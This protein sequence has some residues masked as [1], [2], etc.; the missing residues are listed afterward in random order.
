MKNNLCVGIFTFSLKGIFLGV[1]FFFLLNMNSVNAQVTFTQ[2][3]DAD[4]NKGVLNNVVVSS[5]NVTL[6]NAASNPGLW[7]TGTT[8]LPQNL[9]GHKTATANN[10]Y[11]YL[12]GGYNGSAYSNGVYVATIQSAGISAWTT[13]NALPVAV[14]DPAVVVAANI[15]YVLGGRNATQVFNNIYYA[16]INAD[17]TIGAW[18]TSA[19]ALPVSLWG[20]SA[21]YLNGFIYVAGGTNLPSG[22][23]A[24]NTMYY[25]KLKADNSLS[26]FATGT[27]LPGAR[28][29]HSMV[30]YNNK[31]YLLGGYDNSGTKTNTVYF[32]TP[33]MNGPAGSWLSGTDLPVALSNHSTVVSNGLIMV[34]G[35][36]TSTGL[37]NIIYYAN[38]DQALPLTWVTSVNNMFDF[39]KDGSAFPGN[40]QVIYTG[41][42]SQAGNILSNCRYATFT[43][44]SNY[45][46]HG[47]FVSCPFYELGTERLINSLA[48]TST[49]NATY[50]NCQVSYRLAGSDKIWG[51]WASLTGTSPITVN[52]TKQFVQYSVFL[53]GQ[54]TYNV[55]F[56]DMSFT[57][58]G[59][60]LNG[61]LNSITAFTAAASPY[62]V[63]SSISF[64]SGT[65]T[66]QPGTTVLF[67]PGTGMSVSQASI[68][69]NGTA[70]DS[71][72]FMNLGVDA[73]LWNGIYFDANSNT[74]VSSQF[75]YTVI[76]GAG[77]GTN[78]AN[79][80]CNSTQQ[81]YLSQCNIRNADGN[82][83]TLVSSNPSFQNTVIKG[84]TENG[85]HLTNSNPTATICNISYNASAGIYSNATAS[86]LNGTTIH[87]NFYGIRYTSPNL[88]IAQPVGSPTLND[89]TYNGISIDG[90]DITTS[91]KTWN[92]L[93]YSYFIL[94][95]V[96]IMKSAANVRLTIK[97]G[98]TIKVANGAQI[99]VGN[100][101]SWD[102]Y[103][104][105]LFAIGTADSL[106]TFT[107]IN[108]LA[109]GWNGIYFTDYSDYNGG[110]SQLVYCVIE[111][112]NEYNI[113]SENTIQPDVLNYCKIQN[114][115]VDGARYT[116]STATGTIDH[117]QFLNNGRYPLW[118]Q[119]IETNPVHV[120]NTY[121][122]NAINCIVLSGGYYTFD[123]T[124]YYGGA[125]YYVLSNIFV[126][127]YQARSRFTIMP[128]VTLAF[129]QGTYLQIGTNA[130]YGG[131][132]I[133]EGKP[134]SLIT[135]KPY[136]NSIGGWGG[137]NFDDP[138]NYGS[139]SS[140]KY[141]KIEKGATYNVLCYY[142]T[143]PTMEHCILDQSAG[144]GINLE[145][146]PIVMT[147]CT[148]SNSGAIG[149]NASTFAGSIANCTITNSDS[150]GINASSFTGSILNSTISNSGSHG[151]VA[152]SSTGTVHNNQFLNNHGYPIKYTDVSCDFHLLGN[153][154]I[155]NTP[156]YIALS[157]G[158]YWSQNF[159][160]Y[161]DGIPYHVLNNIRILYTSIYTIKPGVTLAF[162]TGKNLQI[163]TS[164]WNTFIGLNAEGNVDSVITFKPYNNAVGGWGGVYF[165]SHSNYGTS[166]LKYCKIE[167]AAANNILCENTTQPLIEHCE[168]TQSAGSG[169]KLTNSTLVIRNSSF[170]KNTLNGIML[171][172]SSNTAI[173]DSAAN[174]CNLYYNG[175]YNIYNN[176]T[177]NIKA[178]YNFW[179][180]RDSVE[181]K[182]HIY[183]KTDNAA[184]GYVFIR[185]FIDLPYTLT[186]SMALSGTAKYANT[187]SSI[188]NNAK[189]KLSNLGNPV[190]ST[191]TNA[192]GE[193]NFGPVKSG[194]YNL[195]IKPA[196]SWGGVNSTDALL[197]LNHTVHIS[198]LSGI[199]LAAADVNKSLYVN[200]T[201]ALLVMNRFVG[202]ISS[203]PSGDTFMDIDTIIVNGGE[204]DNDLKMLWFGD[205]NASFVPSAKKIESSVSL[206]QEGSIVVPSFTEFNLP[207]KIKEGHEIGAISFGFYYPE[208]FFE[209][210]GVELK[211]S[212]AKFT[213][214]A[215]D[216]LFRLAWCDPNAMTVNDQEPMV[217]LTMKS[218]N[219]AGLDQN[220]FFT[221]YENSELA[222]KSGAMIDGAVL[223]IPAIKSLPYGID[224]PSEEFT[225]KTYPNPFN[226]HCFI[227]FTLI[228]ESKVKII[229]YDYLGGQVKQV[230]E[231][232]YK[233]GANQVKFL[234]PDLAPGFY[235][236]KIE[237]TSNGQSCS[238]IMKVAVSK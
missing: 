181:I 4:F 53:T 6:Q 72:K 216:G 196:Q 231:A 60:A 64:T 103:G 84:N 171:E 230:D 25:T 225:V 45:V 229:L 79:L 31:L 66:F 1:L 207:V 80:Y 5:N 49:F 211:N 92:T 144:N 234:A 161:N 158:D 204:V 164:S 188:L 209:V 146:S 43:L 77:Y 145:S 214:S 189:L 233:K 106:I 122:G 51:D 100:N 69:C 141:C 23:S 156:N 228:K 75:F 197:I 178:R 133:A 94:G 125:P 148:I 174:S 12:V 86:I 56:S 224:G 93:P 76:A 29:M 179:G 120:N 147:N 105:E 162:A 220:G 34:L 132:L 42:I 131:E 222:D 112:G 113:F 83:I 227:D 107:S 58:P 218:L 151:L 235:L 185:P 117:S 97:P 155:G 138:D 61:N 65:H 124:L 57:T 198:L 237:I 48:F 3:T 18:Q 186:D 215:K 50:T 44:T 102:P 143:Q 206:V 126:Y 154:Y 109:G 194:N 169:L 88:A 187:V 201:D 202:N 40:G 47:V 99:W 128:G 62:I 226:D 32:A 11:V 217:T 223:T 175:A 180:S 16:S 95:T 167:K 118:F 104:G 129:A 232:V 85:L 59:T 184:K 67:S 182:S 139:I 26:A 37:S 193:F 13:L 39:I 168:L 135:F 192:F 24:L 210:T 200:A 111:K 236:L 115:V 96:R 205:V 238:K 52:Q 176:T 98:N 91:D 14:R 160:L 38:L 36:A 213:Y 101:Y 46:N 157:G 195:T 149:I 87:H 142:T 137:I 74:G 22:S 9:S 114:A 54:T 82:G 70:V 134:D 172:G 183:D 166:S 7:W 89:N 20:H 212:S 27:D 30:T 219:L 15:I 221:I 116:N 28:N 63:F 191:A 108:G 68:V 177:N 170:A 130:S 199:K 10:K 152:S 17:G 136:N 35:G 203:F 190:D 153:T 90:G 71:V 8:F 119:T 140:L 33:D 81:P 55:T 159:T 41:G 2:T 208:E 19:V 150:T 78:N 163:G 165:T 121:L 173:G 127:K 73:G 123:R 21:V 110:H